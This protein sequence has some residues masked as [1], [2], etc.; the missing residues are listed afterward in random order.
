MERVIVFQS[1]ILQRAQGVNNSA[2]IFKSILFRLDYWN[3]GAFDRLM[4]DTY[5]S[6]MIYLG[7]AHGTQ[8]E[9]QRH[10]TFSNLIL[11]VKLRK[12]IQFVYDREKGG[13]LQPDYLKEDYTGT[14]NEI[15]ASVL[16]GKHTSKT[17]PSCATLEMYEETPIFIPV[18]ITE[19]SAE[20]VAHKI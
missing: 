16:E 2:Q 20:S 5:N 19:E 10:R 1:V 8:T 18:D 11:K 3:R 17:I 12:A 6:A 7:K 4:K 9:E 15:V 13:V 14:I